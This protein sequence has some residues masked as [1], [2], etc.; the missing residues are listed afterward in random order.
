MYPII[1]VLNKYSIF[2]EQN[3]DTFK[4][5]LRNTDFEQ[6]MSFTS[7]NMDYDKFLNLYKDAFNNTFPIKTGISIIFKSTYSHGQMRICS[8]N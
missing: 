6:I 4:I 3:I 5:I 7:A 8:H 2:S 1:V